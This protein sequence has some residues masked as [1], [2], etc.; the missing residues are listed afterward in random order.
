MF[1][2]CFHVEWVG[3]EYILVFAIVVLWVLEFFIILGVSVLQ[4]CV[5]IIR[6]QPPP[7]LYHQ[8]VPLFTIYLPFIF[9]NIFYNCVELCCHLTFILLQCPVYSH[10]LAQLFH[11]WSNHF[12]KSSLHSYQICL[13]P[14]FSIYLLLFLFLKVLIFSTFLCI[15]LTVSYMVSCFKH[16]VLKKM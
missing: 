13:S 6:K 3:I 9:S 12:Y 11:P 7:H 1:F 16:Y 8:C 10:P 5:L 14:S 4:A 2:N 15:F